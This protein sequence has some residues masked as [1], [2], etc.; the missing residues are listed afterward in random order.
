M[1]R[2]VIVPR[3]KQDSTSEEYLGNVQMALD[4]L[5]RQAVVHP[6]KK[7]KVGNEFITSQFKLNLLEIK[8]YLAITSTYDSSDKPENF[9][10][11]TF[12][13][14]D[15]AKT[16]GIGVERGY[17]KEIERILTSLSQ[18]FIKIQV[19]TDIDEEKEQ[20]IKG[21]FISSIEAKG[22]GSVEIV[23][24]PKLMKYFFNIQDKYTFLEIQTL[25]SFSSV[26]SIRIFNLLKQFPKNRKRTFSVEELKEML[27]IQDK[28]KN[29]TDLKRYVLD[30]A[31]KD[32]NAV[33]TM[34][35][36]YDS[37]AKR[38]KKATQVT[39]F[40]KE[41]DL[42]D[43]PETD[44]KIKD[45]LNSLIFYNV[46]RKVSLDIIKKYKAD[47]IIRNIEYIITTY[48]KKKKE[49]KEIAA[50]IISAIKQD[51]AQQSWD[52]EQPNQEDKIKNELSKKYDKYI[53]RMDD[54]QAENLIN[55]INDNIQNDTF[56]KNIINSFIGEAPLEI[57]KKFVFKNIAI[58]ILC[59][60]KI[61]K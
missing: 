27:F 55:L 30:P 2:G 9:Y 35:V 32:I 19:R 34:Q 38:G 37:D 22:D 51:Y 23:M 18:R 31:V 36:T 24:D 29:F 17:F 3:K 59:E 52:V 16:I 57:I 60:K 56:S 12:S 39:F 1:K 40:Y 8:A 28:Y 7:V 14:R 45:A 58:P 26:Y 48:P 46:D 41:I 42:L 5:P 20:W 33:S 50:L 21:H 15:L 13:G 4:L 10:F 47:R 25:L 11:M 53:K 54:E 6:E 43:N 61:I 49:K 44:Q